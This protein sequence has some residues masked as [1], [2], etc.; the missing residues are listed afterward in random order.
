MY[1]CN[2]LSELNLGH[3]SHIFDELIYML[4][5]IINGDELQ[6]SLVKQGRVHSEKVKHCLPISKVIVLKSHH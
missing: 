1:E 3:S 2:I 5:Y 6:S 4:N